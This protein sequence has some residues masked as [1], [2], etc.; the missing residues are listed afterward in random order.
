MFSF[1]ASA[2]ESK[3]LAMY[4]ANQTDLP[5]L[6]KFID[7]KYTLENKLQAQLI[8]NAFWQITDMAIDDYQADKV[9]EGISDIEF[10]MHK[11]FNKIGG[12]M[13]KNGY[14]DIWE[15]EARKR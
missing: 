15:E 11:L 10:W 2:A 3:K 4:Y 5:D 12:Y 7:G 13:I 6:I 9:V 14:R 8:I 1:D